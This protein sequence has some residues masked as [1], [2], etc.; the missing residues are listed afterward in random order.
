MLHDD[1]FVFDNAIHTYDLFDEN[2]SRSDGAADRAYQLNLVQQRRAPGE[3]KIHGK[4]GLLHAPLLGDAF[5]SF[6][7]KWTAEDLGR[8][9]FEDSC[10]DMAMA[11]SV[12]SGALLLARE[13]SLAP[14]TVVVLDARGTLKAFAAEDGT[15]WRRAD[16]AIGKAH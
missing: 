2:I 8:L 7:R 14:M 10:T 16:I 1:V 9:L 11:Q 5:S 4:R 12:V 15:P 13:K 3:Q 6:A